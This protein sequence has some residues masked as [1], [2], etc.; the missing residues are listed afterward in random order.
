MRLNNTGPSHSEETKAKLANI[1]VTSQSVIV[2][3]NKTGET[4][5]LVSIRRAAKYVGLHLSYVAKCLKKK[6]ICKVINYTIT[7][8]KLKGI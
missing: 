7:K 8:I 1:I 5:E 3:N 2:T 4:K 6:S